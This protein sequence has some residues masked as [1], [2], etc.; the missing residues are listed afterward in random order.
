MNYEES[1][2]N[3]SKE[4]IISLLKLDEQNQLL[5]KQFTEIKQ[6]LSEAE[7]LLAWFKKQMFGKKSEK[8]YSDLPESDSLQLYL[9]QHLQEQAQAVAEVKQSEKTEVS[10]YQRG[11]AKKIDLANAVSETGLRFDDTVPVKTIKVP[12]KEI[13]G[14]NPEDYEVISTKI[15]YHLA[16]TN[17]YQVLKYEMD[18]I[19]IKA[20]QKLITTP[21]PPAI[22]E[23]SIADISF[24]ARLGI[25]KF[26]YHMPLYRQEQRLKASGIK[27]SRGTLV[28]YIHRLALLLEPIYK[29][30]VK[31]IL[32]SL[33]LAMDE[34]PIKAG[35]DKE[36]HQMQKCYFWPMYGEEK[37]VAFHFSPT[38]SAKVLLETLKTNFTGI[39]LTD[40]YSAYVNYAAAN[41]EVTHALCWSH[42][43]RYFVKAENI[44]PSLAKT[45]LDYIQKLYKIEEKIK[46][47]EPL[48]RQ[49]VR[50]SHS[51]L[52]VDDFFQWLKDQR[53]KHSLL[54][55]SPFTK[56]MNYCLE[57]EQGLRVFLTEPDLPL[58]TNHV[59]RQIRPVVIGRK[60][61]LFC[62][63][64]AGAEHAGIIFSLIA[65]CRLH[66]IDPYT[67]LVDVLQRVHTH[68]NLKVDELTPRL[69]KEKF[70]Q[71]PLKSDID[72]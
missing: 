49:T 66:E 17:C 20:S 69:W 21:A 16:Q 61:W 23:N 11:K 36:K 8:R 45:A 33:I 3:L 51:K 6:K 5:Q 48:A 1:A 52:I 41:K 18:V 9:N 22:F 29:A 70:A 64:E 44:E 72:L 68:S 12:N 27:I 58:D 62:F 59:E 63:S 4:K 37:E 65:T 24:L 71:N 38:R 26:L 30:Q 25:D 10:T 67:Y 34:V 13:E 50:G 2:E 31:S 47:K 7:Q 19:K 54:P 15:T 32:K 55:N 46:N 60:N 35:V 42:A 28:E 39:L 43:R 40:G 14:L 57:R 56:A 53:T